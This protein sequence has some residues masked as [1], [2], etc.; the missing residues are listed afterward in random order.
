VESD[1]TFIINLHANDAGTPGLVECSYTVVA[2]RTPTGRVLG[3]FK[4]NRYRATLP[5]PCPLTHG[6]ISIIGAGDPQC[7]FL[8]VSTP[9][10]DD[11]SYCNL[12]DPPNQPFDLSFCLGGTGGGVSGACCDEST[13]NCADDVDIAACAATGQR[14]DAGATCAELSPGCAVETGACCRP[15][16]S[17]GVVTPDACVADGGRWLGAGASCELCPKLGGCCVVPGNCI[18]D[19]AQDC[20]ALGRTFAGEGTTCADCPPIPT[21][22]PDAVFGQFPDGPDFFVAYQSESGQS[23]RFEHLPGLA[24]TVTDLTWWGLDLEPL[25]GGAFRECAE[26]SAP[27]TISFHE[28]AAGVPGELVC[29]YTLTPTYTPT[30]HRYGGT[31]LNEYTAALPAPCVVRNPWVSLVGGGS[32]T[33]QFYWMSAPAENGS[34]FCEGCLVEFSDFD[35]NVCVS[36][37]QGGVSG[38]CCD[39]PSAACAPGI[40]IAYC[41]GSL[42][43][44]IP[45]G[46]CGDFDPPCGVMLGACC[47]AQTASCASLTQ[48]DCAAQQGL[49]LGANSICSRCPCAVAC[50]EG[51]VDE[52]EVTCFDD[53]EDVYNSGCSG[54]AQA[55]TPLSPG[56]SACGEGGVHALG[57][58]F[59]RDIDWYVVETDLVTRLTWSVEAT[60][61]FQAW[62]IDGR[63]GCPGST[64]TTNAAL[65]CDPLSISTV[66]SPG[67]Y[68]LVV[69]AMAQTDSSACGSARYTGTVTV[70]PPNGGDVDGDGDIDLDDYEQLADCLFGP[71]VQPAPAPPS[72]GS[73]CLTTFDFDVDGDVDLADFA[74]FARVGGSTPTL[75]STT[76]RSSAG[77]PHAAEVPRSLGLPAASDRF[78]TGTMLQPVTSW[79]ESTPDGCGIDLP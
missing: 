1:N 53:Y 43:R 73:Q 50:P 16:G 28:D 11:R 62:I 61:P 58:E 46:A 42:E 49:W 36:G 56:D 75:R 38:A 52:G 25:G 31:T 59:V 18:L 37:Q 57:E 6:W 26:L 9:E 7:H 79:I 33:C 41:T 34:H 30:I 24:G 5:T 3:G 10:V 2:T 45:G 51:G 29:T 54:E 60:F 55:F 69:G 68:W 76:F 39:G 27:F 74:W 64:L 48:V 47:F 8:W 17:C 78:G 70:S 22:H 40:D 63:F 12:C 19:T 72:T 32:P 71:E 65:E 4:E 14:F 35:L 66:V 44:F 13:G 21:C 77:L 15:D 67:T 23:R 20:A